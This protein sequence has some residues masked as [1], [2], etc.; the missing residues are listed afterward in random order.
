MEKSSLSVLCD[1]LR[2]PV[3]EVRLAD[4]VEVEA[5]RSQVVKAENEA[6]RARFL[7]AQEAARCLRYEDFFRANG[8]DPASVK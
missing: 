8:I 4:A 2:H 1:F 3:V 6:S 5:L 7:Y